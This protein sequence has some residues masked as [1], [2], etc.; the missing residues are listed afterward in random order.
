[1]PLAA[2]RLWHSL[3]IPADCLERQR[4]AIFQR[5]WLIRQRRLVVQPCQ[6][7]FRPYKLD[8]LEVLIRQDFRQA[9]CH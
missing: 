5:F 2:L 7:M 6:P 3:E 9:A 8:L 1:M 4:L